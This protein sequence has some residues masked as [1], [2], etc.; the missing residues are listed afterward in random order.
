MAKE[1]LQRE[2]VESD[3]A[4]IFSE[5]TLNTQHLLAKAYD[6]L[7][8]YEIEDAPHGIGDLKSSILEVFTPSQDSGYVSMQEV[9]DR[10]N[11]LFEAQ[12]LGRCELIVYRHGD[13][14]LDPSDVWEAAFSFFESVAP[15]G[16]YFGS[17]EGDSSCI[18]WFRYD[19]EVGG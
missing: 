4:Y 7:V 16:Y 19:G 18:G 10:S 17:H 6:Q 13:I 8:A 14:A 5:G 15:E 9:L 3:G 11:G 2:I 1:D 12:Y